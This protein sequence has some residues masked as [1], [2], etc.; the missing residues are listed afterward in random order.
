MKYIF[1]CRSGRLGDSEARLRNT[2]DQVV[3][4]WVVRIEKAVQD[5]NNR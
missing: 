4:D 1:R 2:L 5:S 3:A